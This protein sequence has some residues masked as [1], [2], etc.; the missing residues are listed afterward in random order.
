MIVGDHR[1]LAQLGATCD[2]S[3]C[4]QYGN[5]F[6]WSKHKLLID[7]SSLLKQQFQKPQVASGNSVLN[8]ITIFFGSK[9]EFNDQAISSNLQLP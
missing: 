1:Q 9:L 7:L 2:M 4:M 5:G 3:S 6:V 8:S